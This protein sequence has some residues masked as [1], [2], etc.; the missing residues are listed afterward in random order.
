VVQRFGGLAQGERTV[1]VV[2][3]AAHARFL[4]VEPAL[5]AFLAIRFRSARES[6][7]VAALKAKSARMAQLLTAYREVIE[8]GS[9]RWSEAAL[10]RLGEAYSDFNKGLLEAPV[11]RGL[12]PE[13]QELYRTTLQ[14]QA[15]PLENKAVDA[16]REA[17]EL[18]H[19]TGFY[20]E[21]TLRAQRGLRE[22]R[23]DQVAD[24]HEPALIESGVARA[25]TPE[26]VRMPTDRRSP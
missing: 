13:Q 24:R 14:R 15:L 12:D 3:A 20:S 9:A 8:L 25:I 18:S 2:D 16:F 26:R 17:I 19:R 7:V 4:L 5:D 11:P 23:P 6:A 10:T 1:S 21:W 22:Y